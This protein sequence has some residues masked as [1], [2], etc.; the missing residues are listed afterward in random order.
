[1]AKRLLIAVDGTQASIAAVR[2]AIEMADRGSAELRLVHVIDE[3]TVRWSERAFPRRHA[4]DSLAE[5]GERVLDEALAM[6]R[7]AAYTAST[8]RLRRDRTAQ[9]VATLIAAE[10]A[11]WR[12]DLI[13]VGSRGRGPIRRTLRGGLEAQLMRHASVPVHPVNLPRAPRNQRPQPAC[14]PGRL[15]LA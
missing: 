5:E 14:T 8:A 13:L 7:T 15:G 6:I 1:M 9:G 4:I 3:T 10:A 11:S 2:R 12:A